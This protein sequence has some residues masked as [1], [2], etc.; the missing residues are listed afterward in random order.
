MSTVPTPSSSERLIGLWLLICCLVLLALIMLGGATRLTGSG[1]SMVDWRPITGILPPLNDQAWLRVFEMYRA[2]PEYQHI[3]RGMSLAEFK[4]IFWFE[5]AHRVLARFLG[6]LFIVPL[7]W[8]WLRG[9]IPSRLRW[10]LL[11]LLALGAA[12]GYLGWYMVQ[13]GLVDEPRVSQYRLAAHLGLALVIYAGMLWLAVRLLWP[14]Q[15]PSEAHNRPRVFLLLLAFTGI[16]I[17]SGAFVAGLK[18]GLIYNTFP[19]MG[20][21][22]VP[23]GLWA[24]QPAWIN[25]FE[26]PTTAQFNHRLLGLSTL[27]LVL[28]ITGLGLR[29]TTTPGHRGALYALLALTSLQVLL[30]ITALLLHVPVVIGTLHQGGAVLLLSAVLVVGH[31]FTPI[32]APRFNSLTAS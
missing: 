20:D 12:Q 2:S 14:R 10:P 1:L 16:T 28:L 24:L 5:Y 19:L 11:G 31:T 30:G 17:L 15:A 26:N 18:A 8:F 13:S 25:L 21:D 4:F 6:L 22:W 23:P 9:Q 7:V 32:T 29:H 3:N 27:V